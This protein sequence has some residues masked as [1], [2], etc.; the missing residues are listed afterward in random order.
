[1][2]FLLWEY[3]A[4]EDMAKGVFLADLHIHS[5]LSPCADR[6]MLPHCIILEAREKNIDLIAITDHNA[7]DNVEVTVALGEKFGIWVIPGL[8]VETREEIHLLSLFPSLSR[9]YD[10]N[11]EMEKCLPFIPLQEKVWGE[12]WVI[13]EEG[14]I[15]EKKTNL[16]VY[17]V[18]LS[19]EQ[20]VEKTRSRGGIVIPAHVDRPSYSII[21][22]LGFIPPHLEIKVVE[23]SINTSEEKATNKL[24]LAGFRFLHSSDAHSLTQIGSVTTSFLFSSFPDWR[25]LEQILT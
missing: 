17:P 5:V 20:V 24:G 23:L 15:K 3:Q 11:Q 19:V 2:F 25:E 4:P 18:D 21:S 13:N 7:C 9:L 22:Q 8:E 10:F 16:L 1:M 6:D 12:E 14:E